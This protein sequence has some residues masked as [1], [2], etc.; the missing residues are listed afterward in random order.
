[1]LPRDDVR[2]EDA[3]AGARPLLVGLELLAIPP[4]YGG[5]PRIAR[6]DSAAASIPPAGYASQ[7]RRLTIVSRPM[8][9]WVTANPSL[10][11]SDT[12]KLPRS[13]LRLRRA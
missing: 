7:C 4:R 3:F 9:L 12:A 1:L 13:M 11:Y 8:P 6:S 5:R 10:R 2:D